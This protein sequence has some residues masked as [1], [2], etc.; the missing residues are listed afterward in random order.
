MCMS[1]LPALLLL[2][3]KGLKKLTLEWRVIANEVKQSHEFAALLRPVHQAVQG[4]APRNANF[5]KP[6]TILGRKKNR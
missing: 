3:V 2:L 1:L 4:C 6:F 5:I